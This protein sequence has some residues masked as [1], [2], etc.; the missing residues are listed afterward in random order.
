MIFP[1]GS[2]ITSF[3]HRNHV[4]FAMNEFAGHSGWRNNESLEK[5]AG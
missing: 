4:F 2:S 3:L 5:M 1:G